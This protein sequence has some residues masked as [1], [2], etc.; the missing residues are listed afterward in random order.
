MAGRRRSAIKRRRIDRRVGLVI[1]DKKPVDLPPGWEFMVLTERF[2]SLTFDF[3]PFCENGREE[4]AM[5]FRDALWALRRQNSGRTLEDIGK[6][7]IMTFWRFLDCLEAD[8]SPVTRLNQIDHRFLNL[9]IDWL[10]QQS[11]VTGKRKGKLWKV[12]TRRSRY[13]H[14]KT[15]LNNRCK[16]VPESVSPHL[17][18]PTNPFPR[19]HRSGEEPTPYTDTE[20]ERI[21]KAV[22]EDLDRFHAGKWDEPEHQV[23]AIHLLAFALL[24]GRNPQPLLELR[25]G[26]QSVRESMIP[27]RVELRT[28]K[29]RGQTTHV[30]SYLKADNS[31]DPEHFR[32]LVPADFEAHFESLCQHTEP[33]VKDAN[34]E[35]KECVFLYRLRK[36]NR[37]GHVVRWYDGV[38]RASLNSFVTRH[39]LRDDQGKH[40]ALNISRIRVTFGTRLYEK[41]RDL[42]Q[43]SRALGHSR[44]E[45]TSRRYVGVT[46]EAKRNFSIVVRAMPGWAT[47]KSKKRAKE[48][49][50]ELNVSLEIAKNLLEGGFNNLTSR[51]STPFVKEGKKCQ[52]WWSCLDEGGCPSAV[53]FEDDLYKVYSMYFCVLNLRAR[54]GEYL[55]MRLYGNI[56]NTVDNVIAPKFDPKVVDA[57]KS[58]AKEKPHPAWKSLPECSG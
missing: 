36:G 1:Q 4:L 8:G 18:F 23:L 54:Y 16:C 35:D 32:S 24:S 12:A 30:T 45:I 56:I 11:C 50:K 27:G 55:W 6:R 19:S 25:R 31:L 15:V 7:G 14:L 40:L 33:L 10:G 9:Y 47:S 22:H 38:A 48:L 3:N 44:V 52:G 5:H 2:G 53:V 28:T 29:Y 57:A 49:S 37:K 17:K 20:H 43:T 39:D 41:T 26:E 21:V 42:L 13:F 51:C 46:P 58:K 34:S